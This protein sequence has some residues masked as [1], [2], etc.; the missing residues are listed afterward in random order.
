MRKPKIGLLGLMA[1]SYEP[2]F[3]GIVAR[4]EAFARELAA[5][6]SSVADVDFPGAALDRADIEQKCAISTSR[7]ATVCSS[8]F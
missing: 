7:T 4:Q 8:S 1:G 2:I 6:F 5:S 3:P